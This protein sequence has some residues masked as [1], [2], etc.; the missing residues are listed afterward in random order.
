[1]ATKANIN[2]DQGTDFT[3]EIDLSDESGNP[4]D[5]TAFTAESQIRRWYSSSNAIN[6]DVSL[7]NGKVFLSMN[8]SITST[9]TQQRYVYDVLLT[10][11]SNNYVTR[12]VEG[13]VTVNPRVTIPPV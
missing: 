11:T 7:S 10:L 12:I 6:F 4:L 2:I 1:M 9:L 3:T 13:I 5:L 8:S